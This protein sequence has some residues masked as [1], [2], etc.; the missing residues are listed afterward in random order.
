MA[1]AQAFQSAFD[2]LL[3]SVA[4]SDAVIF[5]STSLQDVFMAAEEIQKN[6]KEEEIISKLFQ[7]TAFCRELRSSIE[8][9]RCIVRWISSRAFVKYDLGKFFHPL[10]NNPNIL[11]GS[12]QDD[13]SSR[14]TDHID[15]DSTRDTKYWVLIDGR[16][17]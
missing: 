7:A 8:S 3:G 12:S 2:Q 6:S 16:Q 5:Q 1:E 17:A 9:Y 4:S 13:D 15:V 14:S 10:A 11:L